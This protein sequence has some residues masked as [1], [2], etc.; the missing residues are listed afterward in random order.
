MSGSVFGPGPSG[1]QED[2][3][4]LCPVQQEGRYSRALLSSLFV[5][6]LDENHSA[7]RRMTIGMS[8]LA[9]FWYPSKKG[10]RSTNCGQR[11]SF[12]L[13]LARIADMFLVIPSTSI[14]V[15]GWAIRLRNQPGCLSLPLF[16]AVTT[17]LLP[18]RMYMT[19]VTR[20]L[21]VF[22]PTVVRRSTGIPRSLPILLPPL[23]R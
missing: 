22:R 6:K 8:R 20:R 10:A 13:V 4:R 19:G 18:S 15:C 11:R 7:G 16:E 1:L 2:K 12:S 23:R 9:L 17:K 5:S 14:V 21:P 3:L